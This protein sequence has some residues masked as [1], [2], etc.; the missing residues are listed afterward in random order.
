MSRKVGDAMRA[1][2]E[3]FVVPAVFFC[4]VYPPILAKDVPLGDDDAALPSLDAAPHAPALLQVLS[5]RVDR[6]KGWGL[7]LAPVRDE[8]PPHGVHHQRGR[9]R[10]RPTNDGGTGAWCDVVAGRKVVPVHPLVNVKRGI[11][12]ELLDLVCLF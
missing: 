9:C 7:R 1:F 2:L 8:A 12:I 6:V 5:P 3:P 10:L 11:A 4:V